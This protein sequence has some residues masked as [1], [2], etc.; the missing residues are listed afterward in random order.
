MV[1]T[2]LVR[3]MLV[4]I[5]AGLLSFGFL[6]VYGEPQVDRAI[7]F[8]AQMDEEKAESE[9]NAKRTH[10]NTPEGTRNPNSSAGR[11]KPASACSSRSWSTA[12]RSADCSVWLSLSP[13]AACPA[14]S[15]RKLWPHCWLLD[16][17]CRHLSGA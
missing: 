11:C 15:V 3:G 2:L 7:A 8:E 6:K 17:L 9:Q 4:G 5:V 16:W 13:R 14:N 10:A 12:R 1:R